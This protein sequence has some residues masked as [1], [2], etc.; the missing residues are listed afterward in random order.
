MAE[1]TSARPRWVVPATG[2]L[3]LAA[4]ANA[5]AWTREMFVGGIHNDYAI[6]LTL[7]YV[8]VHSGWPHLYD[9]EAT[10]PVIHLFGSNYWPTPQN[11]DALGNG[12][13]YLP[14]TM[15]IFVPF[16]YLPYALGDFVWLGLMTAALVGTWWLL[17]PRRWRLANLLLM[18]ALLPVGFALWLGQVVP[19]VALSVAI[20]WKLLD[21]R[22]DL[23]AGVVLAGVLIKPNL[24]VLVPLALIVN[25]RP[26][27]IAGFGAAVAVAALVSVALLQPY[28]VTQYVDH[29][30]SVSANQSPA[31]I[32]SGLTMVG[33]FGVGPALLTADLVVVAVV[34]TIAH[35]TRS[36]G[37]AAGY[38]AAI[39]GSLLVTTY[40]HW[41]DLVMV[42][43]ALWL[44]LRARPAGRH[45]VPWLFVVWLV[46]AF[47]VAVPQV[48]I[49]WLA[50]MVGEAAW[51]RREARPVP[52]T[53]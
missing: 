28:G 40:L 50:L 47:T 5:F 8:G 20:S 12:N 27:A 37:P 36:A 9:W 16:L 42:L 22:R 24:A 13:Q 21:E 51:S 4:V 7:T 15:L 10:K 33:I 25:G 34:I 32:D 17:A 53:P 52:T 14:L 23:L 11:S 45:T 6:Y 38:A 29:L 18:F 49:G 1:E 35:I 3:G 31:V 26:R 48:L 30:R 41:Q 19:L 39:A 46:A 2:L 44:W 43:P